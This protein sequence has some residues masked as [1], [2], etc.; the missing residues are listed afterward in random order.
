MFT[1]LTLLFTLP[2]LGSLGSPMARA[3]IYPDKP[4]KFVVPGTPGTGTDLIARHVAASLTKQWNGAPVVVDN[5]PGAGS[6]IGADLVAKSPADGYTVLFNFSAHYTAYLLQKVPFDPIADFEPIARLASTSL[7]MVTAPDS[8]FKTVQ[9]VMQQ[10]GARHAASPLPRLA[11][12]RR[13]T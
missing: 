12:A 7:L 10:P 4:V 9:D 3:Q 1:R 5:R 2:A 11:M 8:P 13:H 6:I